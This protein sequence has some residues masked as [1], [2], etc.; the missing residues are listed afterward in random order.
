MLLGQSVRTIIRM[1]LLPADVTCDGVGGQNA[2]LLACSLSW[3]HIEETWS[4]VE[5]KQLV[6]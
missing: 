4:I 3:K 6:K 1:L 2:I 5:Y